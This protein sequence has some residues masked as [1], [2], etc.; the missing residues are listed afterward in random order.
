MTRNETKE[1]AKKWRR[2]PISKTE[3]AGIP[4]G[5]IKGSE[6]SWDG[7]AVQIQR[8]R[9]GEGRVPGLRAMVV[10]IFFLSHPFLVFSLLT[11][12][13]PRASGGLDPTHRLPGCAL[14]PARVSRGIKRGF[15]R[16]CG[17]AAWRLI[18]LA[19]NNGS[20][21]RFR[22]GQKEAFNSPCKIGQEKLKKFQ[23]HGWFWA[24][25]MERL[26]AVFKQ[27]RIFS[28]VL[29]LDAR[30]GKTR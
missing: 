13:L 4:C 15:R 29:T 17:N 2:N 23:V 30:S 12:L 3:G 14:H 24:G 19:W 11:S 7:S 6:Q 5:Y 20:T 18:E 22:R 26:T 25:D 10:F 9:R 16:R 8:G 28:W 27:T 1:E 21:A